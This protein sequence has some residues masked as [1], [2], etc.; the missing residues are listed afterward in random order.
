MFSVVVIL[1][2]VDIWQISENCDTCACRRSPLSVWCW[3]HTGKL[4][5]TISL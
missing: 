3:Q 5:V 1:F 2:Q 4:R